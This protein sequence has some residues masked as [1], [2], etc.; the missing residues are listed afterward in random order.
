MIDLS[1]HDVLIHADTVDTEELTRLKR[2][3]LSSAI[4]YDWSQHDPDLYVNSIILTEKFLFIAGP[5]AI[6]NEATVEALE[7]WQGKKGGSLWSLATKDGRRVS[8]MQLP[9]PPVHEGMAV[10]YGKLYLALKDGSAICL[11][12]RGGASKGLQ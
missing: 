6:R 8:Q 11:G 5:P 1:S 12:R 4:K 3:L 7:K 2:S 9:S 10:A